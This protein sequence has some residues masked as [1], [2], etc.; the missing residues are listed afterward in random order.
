MAKYDTDMSSLAAVTY[1]SV[2]MIV[3]SVVRAGSVTPTE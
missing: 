2:Y 1:D 3:D